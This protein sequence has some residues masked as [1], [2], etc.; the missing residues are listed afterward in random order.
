MAIKADVIQ[1]S[2]A[3]GCRPIITFALEYPRCIHG[4]LMTHRVFSRNAMSS[5]A[6]PVVKM[7]QQVERDPFVPYEWGSNQAGMQSGAEVSPARQAEAEE[8][9]RRA[10]KH[11]AY[12]ADRLN[13]LGLHKQIVN[14]LLEPFQWMR[15]IV[16]TTELSNFYALRDH[17]AAEPHFQLLARAMKNAEAASTPVVRAADPTSVWNWHLPYVHDFEREALAERGQDGALFLARLS[18]ARCAR[19]SYLNHDGT[20]PDANKDLE[21]F[22]RLW[23]AEPPHASPLEHQAFPAAS[24]E[25][26]FNNLVGWVQFRWLLENQP[27]PEGEI[28]SA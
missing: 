21:L 26:K 28:S 5:R 2:A 6:V 3:E 18:T 27:A 4:E 11:A 10:A 20:T 24:D 19:V 8:E 23:K 17:E 12:F 9:W 7:I 15:T 25:I 1:H 13:G 14:R 22:N 16:T